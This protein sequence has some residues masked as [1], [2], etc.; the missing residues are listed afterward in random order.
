MHVGKQLKYVIQLIQLRM[1]LLE[2]SNFHILHTA[3]GIF[4]D[5]SSL[6]QQGTSFSRRR[7]WPTENHQVGL[8]QTV[9]RFEPTTFGLESCDVDRLAPIDNENRLPNYLTK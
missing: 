2:T 4:L 6:K 3:V 7:L 8:W 5:P 9:G 1:E